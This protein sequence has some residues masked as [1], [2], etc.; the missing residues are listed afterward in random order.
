MNGNTAKRWM[1]A[2]MA[3]SFSE[4]M[5]EGSEFFGSESDA[6]EYGRQKDA[7]L[8]AS[9]IGHHCQVWVREVA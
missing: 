4:V 5:D 8:R 9:R 2:W 7:E 1:V 6:W 3:W